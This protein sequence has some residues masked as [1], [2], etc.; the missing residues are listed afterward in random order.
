MDIYSRKYD[1]SFGRFAKF[2]DANRYRVCGNA[3]EKQLDFLTVLSF[4]TIV[5]IAEAKWRETW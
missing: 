3:F 2:M 4:P 1:I 5:S